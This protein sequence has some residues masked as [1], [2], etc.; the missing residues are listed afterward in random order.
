MT[1]PSVR[2]V[3]TATVIGLSLETPPMNPVELSRLVAAVRS[4]TTAVDAAHDDGGRCVDET[5]AEEAIRLERRARDALAS[6]MI[7]QMSD[8]DDSPI[9]I[10]LADGSIVTYCDQADGLTVVSPQN[11]HTA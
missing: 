10:V 1:T 4:A 2:F 8:T 5:A 11:V 6:W 3:L 9:A 7:D